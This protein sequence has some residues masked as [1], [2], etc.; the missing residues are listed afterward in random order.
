V[1]EQPAAAH[2][3][4]VALAPV[5]FLSLISQWQSRDVLADIMQRPYV[6]IYA[7]CERRPRVWTL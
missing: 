2:L 3:L 5:G 1:G 7:I 4:A 6:Y